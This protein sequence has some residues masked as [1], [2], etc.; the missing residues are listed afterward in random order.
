M[1]KKA[2]EGVQARPAGTAAPVAATRVAAAPK[3]K[4]AAGAGSKRGTRRVVQGTVT[5]TK[6]NKTI[7]VE[8]TTLRK[9]P[10][11]GKYV[12]HYTVMKAHDEKQEAKE[13]DVVEIVETRPI[14]KTKHY[15]LVRI[16]RRAD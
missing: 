7:S 4:A 13:G 2:A 12:R 6:M 16:V 8:T 3:A 1:A 14:S 9:H 10:K 15:R 5:S 11:Y